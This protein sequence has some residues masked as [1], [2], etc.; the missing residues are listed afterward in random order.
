MD[1]LPDI[2]LVDGRFSI[3]C[4]LAS[5]KQM[6]DKIEFEILF[7]DYKERPCYQVMECFARLDAMHGRMAV[8]KKKSISLA[9]LEIAIE[10]F[11]TDYR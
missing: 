8:F 2:V 9:E 4:A 1:P 3:A 7:D 10:R 6:Y 11:S 5:I